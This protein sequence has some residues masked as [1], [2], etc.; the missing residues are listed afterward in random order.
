MRPILAI[1]LILSSL[2][3]GV[4]APAADPAPLPKVAEGWAIEL[5]V[6][7][8]EIM[9]PTA[10]VAARDGT[11]YLGQDPMDMPGPP[12][13]PID[14]I[15][16]I[17]DGKT[18]IFADNL[19]SVMGLEWA[20]GT[21]FVVHAP[22]LSALRDTDGDG[23]A[24]WRLDLMTGLGPDL[25]GFSGI[26]D[27][28]ASGMRLGMDGF[29]Y[30]SVGDKGIPRGVGKDGT[31]IQ[32]FGGGVIRIRTDGTGLEVVSTGERNPLSVALSP[33]DEVFT[34]GNDDDS[35]KWPN[36]LTHHIV[37]GHYGYPYQFLTAPWRALPVLAGQVGG[38]GAQGICYNED[39]LPPS[40]RGNLFFCDWGLREVSRYVVEKAGG[41]FALKAKTP[42]VT[43][44]DL[45]D[46]RPFSIG[47]AADGASLLLVDWAFNGWL[48]DGPKSG[49]LYR[50][51]HAGPDR[52]TPAPRPT[53][54]DPA[55][56]LAALD[57]PARS[58]RL[59]SQRVL[60]RAGP[61][62]VGPLVDRLGKD[63]AGPGRLHAL[64]T[65]DAIGSPEAR[66]SIRGALT[67]HEVEVRLQA[68]RSVGIRREQGALASL[69]SLLRDPD[70][71]VRREAAIALGKLGDPSA[72]A[73]LLAALGDPDAF[74]SWAIRDAIRRLQAWDEAAL[75]DA[76][77]DAKRREDAL[78]LC[79]ESWAVPVVRA[80][81]GAYGRTEAAPVRARIV[82]AMAGLHHKYPAWSGRWFGTNP[83]AGQLPRKTEPWLPEG[84]AGVRDGLARALDDRDPGVRL[85]A[86]AGLREVGKDAAPILRAKLPVEGDE[87]NLVAIVQALGA[88]RDPAATPALAALVRDA[89]RPET[90]RAVALDALAAL[91]GPQSLRAR[92]GLVYDPEAPATLVARALAPLGREGAL[93][94]N[95][96]AGFLDNPAPA[97]RAAAI[98][99]LHTKKPVPDDVK[100]AAL[101]RL[102]DPSPVV[103]MAAIGA[104]GPLNLREA[105]PRLLVVALDET[106][107]TEATLALCAL[108]DPTGLPV[109]LAAIRDRN[110]ELRRAGEAAL[111]AI[112]DRERVAAD[113]EREARSGRLAGPAALAVERV[114]T[115]FAPL[116]DWRVI[117][118]FPRTTAK[119]FVDESSIDFARS[120]TGA[121][122]RT[123]AWS[124][125]RGDPNS[126]R[127]I[128]DDFKG[129]AGDRGGFGYDT[130]GT[131]NLCAF[132]YAE[133]ESDVERSALMLVGSSGTV[134]VKLNGKGVLSY[135]NT[136]GRPYAPD[137]DLVRVKLLKGRNRILV[138]SRQG[139]GVWSFGV[140]ISEPSSYRMAAKPDA[141]SLDALRDFAQSHE[142]DVRKG[143]ELF[144]DPRGIGC[145][146]C[147]AAG[148]RGTANIGPDLTGLALKYD[149][150]EIIRSVLEPSN[151]LAT[152]YQP[153]IVA[154]NDGKVL[155]GL[156]RA[157]TDATLELVDADA[158][159]VSLPKDAIEE[160]RVG[161]VS[162][163][164]AGLIE[165][166]TPID[167]ADLIA[168][169]RSLKAP[170]VPP[171]GP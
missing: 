87:Q 13:K 55:T 168:Y 131:P 166:L 49:R 85:Q 51:T 106:T 134:A 133:F 150:A 12:T 88:L 17:K 6:Q 67:D 113:L 117:G 111:L 123:I 145:V 159:V 43:A 18:R 152:G 91:G 157:E 140:Q 81:A 153:V 59:E 73:S 115:R 97:V 151:R 71:A 28:V 58:V 127:V 144:F 165:T 76:L 21:L 164:P 69:T 98:E 62:V 149:K 11:I 103:R 79:D 3:R 143:E 26:N 129:G 41:T 95:D 40:Y 34:Y 75:V 114:L 119:V 100:Q 35:K 104:V 9:Y 23:K 82:A 80:L 148:G 22:Y 116:P 25:P 32:L 156:V 160:R 101:A 20:D 54:D 8:P 74:A 30:I 53:G 93:P 1:G 167:L 163:M 19:W 107:R 109:Y 112:R 86:I 31:S 61:G 24:D 50:M 15:V 110:P 170:A 108:P 102:D 125:R 29:L 135:Q 45:A 142:G 169:L 92:M 14:S 68:A 161:D 105:L 63:D 38:S 146:K 118:P 37:G 10:I 158:R 90:A 99:A 124:S 66:R 155:T 36:S 128:L 162:I 120:H 78:K 39:G 48:V 57:H 60:V 84:M 132:G 94:P 77:L 138:T 121:E 47:V 64:W 137:A 33:T 126:G 171:S 70:A 16:S 154:L 65:L 83:L 136:A 89:R 139:I 141:I 130:N 46:F 2:T 122:G 96:V 56:R 4:P 52:V 72:G 42:F 147:H 5:L 7:A 27:H 44:G